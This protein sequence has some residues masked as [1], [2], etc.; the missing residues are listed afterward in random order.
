MLVFC[1]GVLCVKHTLLKMSTL[2]APYWLIRTVTVHIVTNQL[3]KCSK[4]LENTKL[5]L[6]TVKYECVD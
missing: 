5:S 3:A 6:K 4:P 2:L 1:M